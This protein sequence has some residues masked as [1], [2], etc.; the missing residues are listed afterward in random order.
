MEKSSQQVAVIVGQQAC[1][2]ANA[3]KLTLLSYFINSFYNLIAQL[4]C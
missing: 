2:V 3:Q 4:C 1:E